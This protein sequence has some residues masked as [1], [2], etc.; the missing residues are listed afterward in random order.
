MSPHILA[1]DV[2]GAP[3]RWINVRDAAHY[4]A[5]DMIA[6]AIGT[7]EFVLR[8]GTQR[9]T[10]L[11]SM[12][13]ASSIIAIKGKDFI[14]RH[15]DLESYERSRWGARSTRPSSFSNAAL[16]QAIGSSRG[17]SSMLAGT[18]PPCAASSFI[19]RLCS[20]MFMAAESLVSPV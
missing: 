5:T 12:I 1:L 16:H 11:Q 3:H 2:A 4:Y 14:V 13:R 20:Q 10:G 17:Q 7:N 8:G 19:T 9:A 18:L 15:F 6:W